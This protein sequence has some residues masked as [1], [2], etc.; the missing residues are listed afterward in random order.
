MAG[1]RV[2]SKPPPPHGRKEQQGPY[3][4]GVA[5]G[6]RLGFTKGGQDIPASL[7]LLLCLS[8]SPH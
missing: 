7:G 3:Q 2:E 4:S 5:V 6:L 8:S 1:G